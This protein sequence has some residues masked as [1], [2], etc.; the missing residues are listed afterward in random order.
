MVGDRLG[1]E[2]RDGIGNLDAV[3]KSAVR[4]L[5]AGDDVSDEPVTHT[6]R[7]GTELIVDCDEPVSSSVTPFSLRLSPLVRG[8]RAIASSIR[9]L[10]LLSCLDRG[11]HRVLMLDSLRELCAGVNGD[12]PLAQCP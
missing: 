2:T 8:A 12:A 4:Q 6:R 1:R 9:R 7:R 5:R 3:L 11:G 10:H